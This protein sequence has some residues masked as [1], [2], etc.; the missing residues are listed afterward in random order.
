MSNLYKEVV[1][2]VRRSVPPLS[3]FPISGF[4]IKWS[5][6]RGVWPLKTPNPETPPLK[7][8]TCFV[9]KVKVK[10]L[11]CFVVARQRRH[12]YKE[13]GQG[14][15]SSVPPLQD[16]QLIPGLGFHQDPDSGSRFSP[17]PLNQGSRVFQRRVSEP[18]G[19]AADRYRAMWNTPRQSGPVKARFWPW[20]S[21]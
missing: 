12:L 8:E 5:V 21:R 14:V 3:S 7:L 20:L 13:M 15:R 1:H 9:L 6:S 16:I 17:T 18:R 2:G 19:S 10:H 4:F 11:R